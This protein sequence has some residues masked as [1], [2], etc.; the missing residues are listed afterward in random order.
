MKIFSSKLIVGAL[1]VFALTIGTNHQFTLAND[2]N[3]TITPKR[4]NESSSNQAWFKFQAIPSSKISESVIVKNLSNDPKTVKLYPA[5]A[6]TNENGSFILK[7]E[8]EI[9]DT[10]GIWTALQ[11]SEIDLKP[12]QQAEIP[13]KINLP[14]TIS[15]GTYSGGIIATEVN[16]NPT[17]PCAESTTNGCKPNVTVRTRIATRIYINVPGEVISDIQWT[18]FNIKTTK[19][20]ELSFGFKFENKGN[21]S[22]EPRTIIEFYDLFGN[23]I[24]KIDRRLGESMPNS[25]IEPRTNFKPEKSLGFV[26]IK[27]QVF[28][29][30]K[31]LNPNEL[32]NSPEAIYRFART[33]ILPW[34]ISVGL[35]LALSTLIIWI[36]YNQ[37]TKQMLIKV[38]EDYA[39]EAE[40]NLE[41]LATSR[42]VN[43]KTLAKINDIKAPF[44]LKPGQIIKLPKK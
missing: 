14:S 3:I 10:I 2:G 25:T 13:F 34:Q 30:P 11:F 12:G 42:N 5:D 16:N 36:Y 8:E 15:P 21:V 24:E 26:N 7:S 20:N 43:W 29:E 1:T 44:T 32:R 31:Y 23:P 27:A 18:D 37:L 41:S 39:V 22:Y 4:N 38:S 6:F 19:H 33:I 28:F 35:F 9:Q 40:D 17:I